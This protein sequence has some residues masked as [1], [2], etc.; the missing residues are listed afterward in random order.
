MSL[1]SSQAVLTWLLWSA[2]L[3]ACDKPN[4]PAREPLARVVEPTH[5]FGDLTEGT[6]VEHAFTVENVGHNPL[7]L[8]LLRGS[9]GCSLLELSPPKV[10]P[11]QQAVATVR[12]ETQQLAGAIRREVRLAAT[13][14]AAHQEL[15]LGVEGDVQPL[16][17]VSPSPLHFGEVGLDNSPSLFVD[18]APAQ[19]LEV[20][21]ESVSVADDRFRLEPIEA[22][23]PNHYQAN[24]TLLPTDQ[25]ADIETALHISI[26][27]TSQHT[28]KRTVRARVRGDL[29]SAQN[30]FL[31]RRGGEFKPRDIPIT[32]RT[33]RRTRLLSAT[34]SS[35]ALRLE[36][37]D[38][39]TP[40]ALVRATVSHPGRSYSPAV[41]GQI[42]IKTSNPKQPRLVIAYILAEEMRH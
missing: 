16:L 9:C 14:G 42:E 1:R 22:S 10:M 7:S 21:I 13:S 4:S 2:A 8:S 23:Q 32:S 20:V 34:D 3:G 17:V 38:D 30:L 35:G 6:V 5:P 11:G 39:E 27:G 15:V 19:G 29:L 40:H 28:L 26:K 24:L 33:G 31:E 12:L 36:V 37:V 25:E 41:S 18:I